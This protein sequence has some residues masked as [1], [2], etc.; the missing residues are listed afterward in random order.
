MERVA[1][2][3]PRGTTSNFCFQPNPS[4]A[5]GRKTST[6]IDI[7]RSAEVG[8]SQLGLATLDEDFFSSVG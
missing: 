8:E 5:L 6:H 4:V 1:I 7:E 3:L 2:S